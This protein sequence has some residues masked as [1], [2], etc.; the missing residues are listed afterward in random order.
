MYGVRERGLDPAKKVRLL[1]ASFL[2]PHAA[3]QGTVL[4]SLSNHLFTVS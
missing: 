1:A 4:P 3:I 2:T